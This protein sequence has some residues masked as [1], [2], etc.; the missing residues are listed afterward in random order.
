MPRKTHSPTAVVP[1]RYRVNWFAMKLAYDGGYLDEEIDHQLRQAAYGR[2]NTEDE[3]QA[4]RGWIA[5]ERL[6]LRD[7]AIARFE[8]EEQA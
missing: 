5:A 1:D 4:L 3:V 7:E 2:A 6:R 8:A